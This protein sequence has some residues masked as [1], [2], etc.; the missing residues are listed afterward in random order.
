MTAAD[1]HAADCRRRAALMDSLR[2]TT[3]PDSPVHQRARLLAEALR[4]RA[5][6]W[7]KLA[8]GDAAEAAILRDAEGALLARTNEIRG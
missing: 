5:A 8:E 3:R 6:A 1:T 7:V 4:C 2:H